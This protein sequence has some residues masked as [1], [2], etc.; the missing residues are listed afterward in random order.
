MTDDCH[1][2]GAVHETRLDEIIRR[3]DKIERN[4]ENN[5]NNINDLKLK[6]DNGGVAVK[7]FFAFGALITFILSIIKL[8]TV[9]K[10]MQ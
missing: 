2:K 6:V 3:L 9:F 8:V 4:Q 10:D 7:V 1:I 5:T